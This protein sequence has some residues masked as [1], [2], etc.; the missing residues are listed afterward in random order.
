MKGQGTETLNSGAYD[1]RGMRLES[2]PLSSF[3][4]PVTPSFSLDFEDGGAGG[5]VEYQG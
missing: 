5:P 4:A 2:K 3:W 1:L